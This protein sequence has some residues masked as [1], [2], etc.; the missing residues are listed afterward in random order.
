MQA[1]TLSNICV[2]SAPCRVH[3]YKYIT[4][5]R[6]KCIESKNVMSPNT[7]RAPSKLTSPV[8]PNPPVKGKD[9][10]SF[11]APNALLDIDTP[12]T[13]SSLDAAKRFCGY[14]CM[15]FL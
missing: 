4:H 3:E 2:V 7:S 13:P 9:M 15:L 5:L 12:L 14:V 8:D 1:E 11:Y 6:D 10:P